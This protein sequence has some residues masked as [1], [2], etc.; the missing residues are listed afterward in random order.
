MTNEGN[1]ERGSSALESKS[2][3]IFRYLFFIIYFATFVPFVL[4]FTVTSMSPT[5]SLFVI[6]ALLAFP[7]YVVYR[8]KKRLD[9]SEPERSRITHRKNMIALVV[10]AV[11]IAYMV[12]DLYSSG[13]SFFGLFV[14]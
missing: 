14:R 9:M 11:V 4:V 7:F 8:D 12:Y 10:V 13:G 5:F 3:K 1:M 2:A 6:V